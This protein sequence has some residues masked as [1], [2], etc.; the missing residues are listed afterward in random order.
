ML[1]YRTFYKST[2]NI[3]SK[4]ILICVNYQ[5]HQL[6]KH[7]FKDLS[8]NVHGFDMVKNFILRKQICL[9]ML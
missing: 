6:N 7:I 2:L 8:V 3:Y 9:K 4:Y 5:S 1:F